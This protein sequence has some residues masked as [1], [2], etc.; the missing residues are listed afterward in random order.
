[1]L[2]MNQA[3]NVA[4]WGLALFALDPNGEYLAITIGILWLITGGY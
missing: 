1:M 3:Q 2:S 4:K